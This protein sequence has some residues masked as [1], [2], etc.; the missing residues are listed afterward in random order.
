MLPLARQG[1]Y[2]GLEALAVKCVNRISG[3]WQ[4]RAGHRGFS[5]TPGGAAQAKTPQSG[6]K[7][8]IPGG[9]LEDGA[10]GQRQRRRSFALEA[11]SLPKTPP[12]RKRSRCIL[13]AGRDAKTEIL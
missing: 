2:E 8:F 3:R 12:K 10:C 1:L 4:P 9:E 7:V 11:Y 13:T 5:D 6:R